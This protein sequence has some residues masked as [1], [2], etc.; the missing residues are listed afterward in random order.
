M[1]SSR[2]QFVSMRDFLE[3][4]EV[5]SS[6][7]EQPAREKKE[8][9]RKHKLRNIFR[10]EENKERDNRYASLVMTHHTLNTRSAQYLQERKTVAYLQI[11][12]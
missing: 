4:L 12:P 5:R 6:V 1:L 8:K 2:R 9:S 3:D 7:S 11:I 10:L